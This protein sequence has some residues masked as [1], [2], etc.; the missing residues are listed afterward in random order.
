MWRSMRVW[1]EVAVGRKMLAEKVQWWW[2]RME[3]RRSWREAA[4]VCNAWRGLVLVMGEQRQQAHVAAQ[5]S[6]Y[7]CMDIALSVSV[8]V[9]VS[10][11]G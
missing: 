3:R 10:S 11:S 7:A 6:V 9:S 1:R 4:R 2:E 8:S 5:V